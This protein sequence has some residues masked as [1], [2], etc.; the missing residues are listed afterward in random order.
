MLIVWERWPSDTKIILQMRIFIE[1]FV[2]SLRSSECLVVAVARSGQ[3]VVVTGFEVGAYVA[4]ARITIGNVGRGIVS[5]DAPGGRTIHR[6]VQFAAAHQ[7]L[8]LHHVQLLR[9]EVLVCPEGRGVSWRQG[10]LDNS[11]GRWA[12]LNESRRLAGRIS[13]NYFG[14]HIARSGW[15]LEW[16]FRFLS[17]G[18]FHSQIIKDRLFVRETPDKNFHFISHVLLPRNAGHVFVQTRLGGSWFQFLETL[19]DVITD[20]PLTRFV[21]SVEVFGSPRKLTTQMIGDKRGYY[22]YR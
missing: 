7:I 18:W 11:F 2:E 3:T 8:Q 13:A 1:T 6:S 22:E 10:E 21:M 14:Q 9:S 5:R 16:N 15:R 20:E 12:P 17:F 4:I 19:D